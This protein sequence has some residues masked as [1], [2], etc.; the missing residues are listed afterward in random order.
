MAENRFEFDTRVL[1]TYLA[2][3]V[4]GL[5]G[6]LVLRRIAGGQSNPTYF[7]ESG[8]RRLVLRKRPGGDLLPSAHMVDREY[9]V[10]AALRNTGVA[11]PEM[12]HFCDDPAIIGT[13][14]YVMEHVQGRV[15]HD[16][17]L[18]DIPKPERRAYFDALARMLAEIHKVDIAAAGLSDF[19]RAGG[20][21]AR[22]IRR[23]TRQW[24][25][26]RSGANADVETLAQWLPRNLPDE[27]RTTL[28]HGDFRLGNVMFHPVEPRIVAVL[29]WELST[30]GHPL[31]DLAHTCV[32]TWFMGRNDYG[33]GLLDVDRAAG[34]LPEMDEFTALYFEAAG[35]DNR[36]TRFYLAL[37]LF[38][39][40]VIFE[41]IAS[42]ARQGNAAS[43]DAADVGRLAP[44]LAARGAAL[45]GA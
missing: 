33:R 29:D 18:P 41:G 23:W 4:G 12:V 45:V 14:F 9:R 43:R 34:A 39:N 6:D 1:L 3:H 20:F 2:R 36:L 13:P 17:G 25:L 22:Q 38:R 42:R 30:L 15:L 37:A 24:E 27:D 19:G 31:V 32:Y 8:S 21:A 10:Q 7:L 26:S 40:A 44:V 5:G 35:R 16:N 11:V 28:V